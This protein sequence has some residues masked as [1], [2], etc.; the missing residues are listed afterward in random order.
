MKTEKNDIFYGALLHDIGKVVQR[1]TGER[2]KHAIVGE[3]WLRKFTS[4][5]I[6]L[7]HVK[8]HMASYQEKLPNTHSAYITYIADNIASGIDR[9]NSEEELENNKAL[10]DT[11]INQLDTFNVFGENYTNRYFNPVELNVNEEPNYPSNENAKFT[12]GDYLKIVNRIEQSLKVMKFDEN[13]TSSLLNLL[14][15]TLSFVPASTNTKE[16]GDI[17]LFEHSKLTAAF[18]LSIYDYLDSQSRNNFKTELFENSKQFYNEK[19]FLLVSFD[20]SGIQDFIYNIATSGAAKQLRARSFYLDFIS[21]HIAD[22]LLTELDLTRANLLYIGGGHAY[23]LLPNISETKLVINRFEKQFNQFFLTHV[24]TR[25]YVSFGWSEFSALDIMLDTQSA[26]SYRKIYQTCSQQISNKK[27]KRY[28]WKTLIELNNSEKNSDK[29]CEICHT[30]DDLSEVHGQIL[31]R[32]CRGLRDFSTKI[33]E[34]YFI[35][36]DKPSLLPIGPNAYLNV[37]SEKEIKSEVQGK[38]YAKNNFFTGYNQATHIFVGDY[39]ARDISEYAFLSTQKINSYGEKSGI[40]RLAVLRLDVDNLGA[41]FM[42]GF[43]LQGNGKFNTFSRIA[44]FSRSMSQF[45]K[46]YINQFAKGKNLS[47][48]YS[49]GDDV[50]AIGSWQDIIEFA[51][52]VRQNFIRWTNGKLTLSAGI[53]LFSDKTPV[54][55]MAK[56]TGELENTAKENGKDSICLFEKEFTFK[57]DDFIDK[58]YN[59]NFIK[60]QKFFNSIDERGKTFIYR[61][62][63]LLRSDDNIDIARTAYY[64]SRLEEQSQNNQSDFG[65]FKSF[66]FSKIRADKKSKKQLELAL[67]LYV[68]ETRKG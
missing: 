21:E 67:M 14:E 3:K 20:I 22:S 9:R 12:K 42:A 40:K 15:A 17:S 63:E 68:Y 36:T 41:G 19:A 46:V 59:D 5:D 23:F 16:I 24:K 51:I 54:R 4:N 32:I 62:I 66:F 26:S 56:L 10:W 64:L 49:G 6:I 11:Y 44:T 50:F 47:I 58:I 45:F 18:A 28:D 8:N 2:A 55:T 37:T 30:T 31:C 52:E 1:S 60:V 39:Q 34:N 65:E 7:T 57:F 48:I 43:S 53:G 38:V 27:L 13:Y 29:E 35:V 61:L 33:N 25:L